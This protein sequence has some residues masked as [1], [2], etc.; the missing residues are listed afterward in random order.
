MLIRNAT[1]HDAAALLAIYRPFVTDTTVTL[2][3]SAPTVAEFATR[4]ATTLPDYPYLVAEAGD[5]TPLGYAYA[6]RYKE[7]P[8]YN[9]TVEASIYVADRG[10][11]VGKA[12]YQQLEALL[13]QQHVQTVMACVTGHNTTSQLF[14]QHRGFTEVGRFP[15]AGFKHGQWLD[16]HWFAKQL[17]DGTPQPFIRYADLPGQRSQPA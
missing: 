9:W 11:G 6:H 2:E 13:A 12:L 4:I 5:H 7:R 15:H 8:G 14:H 16:L 1:I 3:T 17:A 10:H